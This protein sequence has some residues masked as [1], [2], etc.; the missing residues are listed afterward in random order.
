[1]VD[2]HCHLNFHKFADDVDEVVQRATESGVSKIV[3]VGTQISSSREAIMLAEKFDSCFAVVGIHPH[4]ADKVDNDWVKDLESLIS[5]EKVIAVG[6]CGLDY[7][8]YQSNGIVDPKVQKKVFETQ[9]EI[10]YRSKLPLVIHNRHAGKEIIEILSYYKSSLLNLPG[11]FHCMSGD[12]DLLHQ[13]LDLGFYVGFDGN[14][15]YPKLAP[16]ETVH[17]QDLVRAA[18][19]DK[20]LIETDSPYLTPIPHRGKRN[21]PKNAIII[22]EF[23]ASLKGVSLE[24]VDFVTTKNFSTVF[25]I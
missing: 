13:V 18:P 7:F 16:G 23:I 25:S 6:E 22:G 4:H 19:L 11:M 15:T 10:A 5:N 21:E 24:E 3:N 8:S 2:S 12:L 14:I 17:L 1:M 20:I 9:I